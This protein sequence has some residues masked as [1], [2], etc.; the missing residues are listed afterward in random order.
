MIPLQSLL[1]NLK[2]DEYGQHHIG[3][4]SV[5]MLDIPPPAAERNPRLL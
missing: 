3:A 1:N 2:I 5:N 4:T